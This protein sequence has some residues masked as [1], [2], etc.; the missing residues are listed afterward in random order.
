MGDA[1]FYCHGPGCFERFSFRPLLEA[2]EQT[3][4]KL[5]IVWALQPADN[6]ALQ[7]ADKAQQQLPDNSQRNQNYS[8]SSVASSIAIIVGVHIKIRKVTWADLIKWSKCRLSQ[9]H[10]Q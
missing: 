5:L 3:C 10:M 1:V 2:H 9:L 4:E 6:L 7:P 8:S